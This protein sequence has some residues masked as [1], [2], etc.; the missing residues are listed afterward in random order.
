MLFIIGMRDL[1]NLNPFHT[2][3]ET[4]RLTGFATF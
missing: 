1:D 2:K 4:I 3:Y